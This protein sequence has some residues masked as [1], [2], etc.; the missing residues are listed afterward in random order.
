[1]DGGEKDA[2]ERER[3]TTNSVL[4]K[5]VE[6]VDTVSRKKESIAQKIEVSKSK[7]EDL[8]SRAKRAARVPKRNGYETIDQDLDALSDRILRAESDVREAE[9]C[10]SMEQEH[11]TQKNI[12]ITKRLTRLENAKRSARRTK[13]LPGFLRCVLPYVRFK[14]AKL[15]IA[16]FLLFVTVVLGKRFRFSR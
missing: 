5:C 9:T 6:D 15:L 8:V 2:R 4:K 1:M 16:L 10:M 13:V 11:M 3:R 7:I 14:S 12:E